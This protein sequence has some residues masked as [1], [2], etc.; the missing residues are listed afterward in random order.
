MKSSTAFVRWGGPA[1]MLGALMFMLTKARVYLDPDDALLG[2]FMA[3]GFGSWLVGLAA[4]SARYGPA[5]GVL[6]KAGIGTY[7]AG[8]VLLAVGHVFGFMTAY[9]L[10]LLVILGAFGLMIGALLFGFAALR[11]EV[12]PRHWRYLPLLTGLAGLAWF[13]LSSVQDGPL[14]FFVPRT[15]FALG[16]LLLGFVLWSDKEVS[17]V[18]S[19]PVRQA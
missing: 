14:F 13:V 2:F 1:L 12:L 7:I 15:L 3:V 4:F 8:I 10:F 11:V 16:W 6:G 19:A 9:D 18:H 5:S 17:A